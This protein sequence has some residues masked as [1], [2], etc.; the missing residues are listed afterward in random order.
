MGVELDLMKPLVSEFMV[1]GMTLSV[2]YE[3]LGLLC[4]KCGIFGHVKDGCDELQ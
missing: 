4:T 2:V 1:E 3:S